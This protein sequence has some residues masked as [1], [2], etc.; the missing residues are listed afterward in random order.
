MC[1]Q[2]FPFLGVHLTPTMDGDM[3]I[4]PNAVLAAAREVCDGMGY[5]MI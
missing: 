4:G 3:L 2:H 1:A 5:D